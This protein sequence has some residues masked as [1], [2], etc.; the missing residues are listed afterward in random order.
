VLLPAAAV[1]AGGASLHGHRGRS[2]GHAH[3]GAECVHSPA[4]DEV[5]W[6]ALSPDDVLCLAEKPLRIFLSGE[7]GTGKTYVVSNVVLNGAFRLF[8]GK[9]CDA[10]PLAF[11]NRAAGLYG[12]GANTVMSYLAARLAEERVVQL[13]QAVQRVADIINSSC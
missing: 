8:L 5:D 4:G 10:Q 2:C 1:G 12:A 13:L 11:T 9:Y 6:G 3:P 7:G